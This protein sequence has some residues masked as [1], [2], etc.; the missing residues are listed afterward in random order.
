MSEALAGLTVT[1]LVL[2]GGALKANLIP[3]ITSAEVE[4]TIS[5]ADTFTLGLRDPHLRILRSGLF[6]SRATLQIPAKGQSSPGGKTNGHAFELVAVRKAGRGLTV[7]FEDLAAA[8]LRRHKAPRKIEAGRMTRVEFART[9]VAEERWIKFIAPVAGAPTKVELARGKVATDTEAAEPED[10]WDALGRL[11][12]DVGWR[13]FT[14]NN[15]VFFM[16]E[17]WILGNRATYSIAEGDPGIDFIDFDWDIGK[18]VA[19]V[20][21]SCRAEQ[22][23]ARPGT[24]VEIRNLP[25]VSGKW[26]VATIVKSL[27]TTSARITMTKARPNLPEP[28][29]TGG[30]PSSTMEAGSAGDYPT[31]GSRGNYRLPG[32]RAHVLEAT[33]EIG[34]RYGVTTVFGVGE[35]SGRSDHPYGLATDLMVGNNRSQ[36]DAIAAYAVANASRLRIKYV[37]WQQRIWQNGS[38]SSMADRGNAT[39]NHRDHVHISFRG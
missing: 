15:Q 37:I 12:D 32:V 31:T 17:T 39:A 24:V 38:W 20:T 19:T 7:I 1:D 10:T 30:E 18:P 36:G 2:N 5:G 6:A 28:D 23:K 13:R 8:A 4:R 27:F 29:G 34:G 9:L 14:V 11:A 22:W 16:P 26:I 33:N 25:P 35:R 3:A 21:V